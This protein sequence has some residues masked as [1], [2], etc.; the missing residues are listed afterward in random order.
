MAEGSPRAYMEELGVRFGSNLI[1]S[2]KE[3]EGV[4]IERK[5]VEGALL[6][7]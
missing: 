4:C 5:N 7:F 6:G 3:R 2:E 1:L